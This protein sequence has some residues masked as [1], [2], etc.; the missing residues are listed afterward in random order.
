MNILIKVFTHILLLLTDSSDD[1][2]NLPR[3]YQYGILFV[4]MFLTFLNLY[5]F[6]LLIYYIKSNII[7]R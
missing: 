5:F 1:K 7:T 6:Y 2:Y 4:V 3:A